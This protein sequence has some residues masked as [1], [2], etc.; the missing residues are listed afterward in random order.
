VE[1]TVQLT[2]H[3]AELYTAANVN[4]NINYLLI[5]FYVL[6]LIDLTLTF[7]GILLAKSDAVPKVKC[8]WTP[9]RMNSCYHLVL[10]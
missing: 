8:F 6:L 7:A 5:I 4:V 1:S 3:P 10:F 2:V 9:F